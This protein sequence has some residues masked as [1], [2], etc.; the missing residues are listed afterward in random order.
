MRTVLM[1]VALFA[2]SFFGVRW[3][4]LGG[5]IPV[6]RVVPLKPDPRLETWEQRTRRHLADDREREWLDSKTAQGDSDPER[7]KLRE[8][9]I[10]TA[11]AFRL[12]PCNDAL[13]KKYIEAAL[14]YARAFVVL[15]GCPNFPI[16]PDNDAVMEHAKKVFR[17]PADARVREAMSAVHEMGIGLKDYPG[18]LGLAIDHL[19]GSSARGN[20]GFSCT[21]VQAVAPRRTEDHRPS[22]Q[23]LPPPRRE[24]AGYKRHDID[25]ETR[26]R[27]RKNALAD[28]RRPG[29]ALC[30]D[31]GRRQFVAGLNQ[32]YRERDTSQHGFAVRNR[33]QQI[34]IEREWS[35]A[36]D[37]QID[38]LVRDFYAQGYLRPKD[39]YKSPTVDKVLS[40]LTWTNRACAGATASKS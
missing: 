35:S 40:G 32:Y 1:V 5:P 39:L 13:K 16:C 17:S 9:V 28:L 4:T 25:R 7:T 38:S 29:P 37:Q 27:V 33:E 2:V 6:L 20:E 18:R 10:E 22:D 3:I 12:S 36:I 14:A 26:E 21:A 23:P 8:A 31:P 34:A 30:T 15:G 11:T 19:S 24:E